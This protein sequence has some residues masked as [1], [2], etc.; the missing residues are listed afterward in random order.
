MTRLEN[1]H[2]EEP[3]EREEASGKFLHAHACTHKSRSISPLLASTTQI[4]GNRDDRDGQHQV[5]SLFINLIECTCM[6]ISHFQKLQIGACEA[7]PQVLVLNT[8]TYKVSLSV[9]VLSLITFLLYF[10]FFLL[11]VLKVSFE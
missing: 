8:V 7:N 2:E 5:N 1:E 6:E 3:E 9:S 4:D 11:S 10:F